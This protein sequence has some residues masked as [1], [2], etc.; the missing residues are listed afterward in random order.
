MKLNLHLSLYVWS[1][2]SRCCHDVI[3]YTLLSSINPPVLINN[4][5]YLVEVWKC[6][7]SKIHHDVNVDDSAFM[8]RQECNLQS[9]ACWCWFYGFGWT[10]KLQLHSLAITVGKKNAG[11]KLKADIWLHFNVMN[12]IE[13]QTGRDTH[14]QIVRPVKIH[15]F[16]IFSILTVQLHSVGRHTNVIH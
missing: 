2:N 16:R 14:W 13:A 11:S 15:M 7:D 6:L 1:Q 8:W 5:Q 12:L 10:I 4:A 3:N 9:V